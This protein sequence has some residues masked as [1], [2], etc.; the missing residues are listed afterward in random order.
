MRLHAAYVF[1][2]PRTLTSVSSPITDKEINES[3]C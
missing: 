3:F 1:K 2:C